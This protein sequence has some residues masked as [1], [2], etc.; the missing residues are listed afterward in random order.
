MQLMLCL[1]V[2]CRSPLYRRKEG[3]L[4]SLFSE[5]KMKL[6]VSP[7]FSLRH[8]W[9]YVQFERL[10]RPLTRRA[11]SWD[12][13]VWLGRG[14]VEGRWRR[15]LPWPSSCSSSENR[16]F[17]G[18]QWLALR[19]PQCLKVQ[20][21][22]N[23]DTTLL[24]FTSCMSCGLLPCFQCSTCALSPVCACVCFTASVFCQSNTGAW[25]FSIKSVVLEK[26]Q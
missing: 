24:E 25:C 23:T 14:S 5:E 20:F 7:T 1:P 2:T 3:T 10:D 8:L 18:W 17:P 22:Y 9:L 6:V 4:W 13:L 21:H 15:P 19:R 16:R 12:S 11:G 26:G